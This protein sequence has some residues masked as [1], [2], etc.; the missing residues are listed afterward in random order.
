MPMKL[1]LPVVPGGTD[2]LCLAFV[3]SGFNISKAN[4]NANGSFDY[5]IFQINSHYWGNDY[6][7]HSE[8]LCHV[9]YQELLNS[10]LLSAINCA[11]RIVSGGGGMNWWVEWKLHCLGRLLTYWMTGCHL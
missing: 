4:E 5:G 6:R 1:A 9:D 10:N 2:G 3:E 7:S 11:K 8:H